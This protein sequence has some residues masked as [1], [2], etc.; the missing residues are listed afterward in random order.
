ME[1]LKRIA[2]PRVLAVHPGYGEVAEAAAV[3]DL[4]GYVDRAVK[5]EGKERDARDLRRT[6]EIF[7]RY[8]IKECF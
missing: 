3:Y 1:M 7:R 5:R 8:G 4:A 2:E 6:F